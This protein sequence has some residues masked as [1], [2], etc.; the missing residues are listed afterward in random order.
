MNSLDS[1]YLRLGDSFA[2]RFV[3]A[4]TYRYMLGSMGSIAASNHHHAHHAGLEI[5]VAPESG[6]KSTTH[7]VNVS[8]ANGTF[9]ADPRT[10]SIKS[11][12]VVLWSTAV[13][14][15]PGFAVQCDQ[16]PAKFNSADLPANS[17]YSHAFGV[18]G[19]VEWSCARDPKLC[20]TVTVGPPPICKSKEDRDAYVSTL[21]A[22]TLVMIDGV[23]AH[24]KKVAVTV[25]QTV[26]FAIR[27]GERVSIVDRALLSALNPQPLPP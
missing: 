27:S 5:N 4:G 1:R 13:A 7:Y 17:M 12:D 25:G 22:A 3:A 11:N 6:S 10:L 16:G 9:S 20:G 8:Y 24:P 14:A 18:A 19:V 23:K 26:F 2:H 21:G 15:T